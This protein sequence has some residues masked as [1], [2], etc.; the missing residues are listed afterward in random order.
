[1]QTVIR[2]VDQSKAL[3]TEAIRLSVHGVRVGAGILIAALARFK[4][5][6]RMG[7]MRA[8]CPQGRGRM[9]LCP[10]LARPAGAVHNLP[11]E[12]NAFGPEPKSHRNNKVAGAGRGTSV[13]PI[14]AG[15]PAPDAGATD[16][17]ARLL[18]T[19]AHAAHSR[20]ARGNHHRDAD[21][22]GDAADLRLG[23]APLRNPRPVPVFLP[24]PHPPI[25]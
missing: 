24:A 3:R 16:R 25:L 20:S 7:E 17:R 10:P 2:T 12:G 23:G 1:M 22:G 11:S 8:A 18:G 5:A 14:Q 15:R 6:T 21:R 4:Q 13:S 9:A 19:I